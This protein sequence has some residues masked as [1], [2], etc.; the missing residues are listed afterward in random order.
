MKAGETITGRVFNIQRFSIQDGPGIRSTVFL[1]EC[2]LRCV[3]CS[4]PESQNPFPEV[5]HRDS[6]CNGCGRCLDVCV[7]GAIRLNSGNSPEKITID[8]KKCTNCARCIETC[9]VGAMK[10]FGQTMSVDEVFDEVR[11]DIAFYQRSEGGVTCSG[12]EPLCQPEFVT[13]LF[14][15]CHAMGIRTAID[16]CGYAS[17]SDLEKV[18]TETDFVLYDL[19]LRDN[20][21]HRKF[22]KKYNTVILRNAKIV[23]AK[24]VP[25][26]IRIPF[27]PGI[28]DAEENLTAIARFVHEL[29][30]RGHVDLLPYHR[31]GENKYTMLDRVYELK[32]AK[33]PEEEQLQRAMEVFKRFNLDCAIQR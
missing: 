26:V 20:R 6:L 18:L 12:G 31:L 32:D 10:I 4:N 23:I 7:P 2:P 11:R 27:I 16:T 29:G 21:A 17:V 1:K 25:M 9:T 13:E 5:A 28:T 14:R 8:R 24:G 33:S 30:Y 3:W 15:R 22:I 19:K